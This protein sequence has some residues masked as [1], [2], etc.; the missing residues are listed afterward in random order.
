M[1]PRLHLRHH[2]DSVR[3]VKFGGNGELLVS[4]SE[5][6][7]VKLWNAKA[8]KTQAENDFNE[9]IYTYR[10][11]TGPLFAL[12]TNYAQ[13]PEETIVYSA[14][15]EGVI[16]IW[17]FPSESRFP[18][19]YPSSDGKNHCIGI[20]SSH[21]DT[22]WQLVPHPTEDLLLSVSADASVK[23]WKTPPASQDMNFDSIEHCTN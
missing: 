2:F 23:M 1:I 10:G 9:P 7:M 6:C 5:D 17:E 21:K 13:V 18:D 11:H 20:F 12:A 19:K 16:R 14:G 8:F 3:D 22:V 15:S 4:A